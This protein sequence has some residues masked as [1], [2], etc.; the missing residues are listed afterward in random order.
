MATFVNS[1]VACAGVAT[2]YKAEGSEHFITAHV[3]DPGSVAKV[4]AGVLKGFSIGIAAHGL[5]KITKH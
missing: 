3:V 5:P 1:T 2:E 4:K